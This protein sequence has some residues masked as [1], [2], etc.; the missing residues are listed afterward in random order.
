MAAVVLWAAPVA[1]DAPLPNVVIVVVDTLRADRVGAN[2]N[3]QSFTPFLDELAGRGTT[4][5]NAYATSSWTCPSV[6]SLL[7]SRYAPQHRTVAFESVLAADEVTL[8][9]VLAQRGYVAGGF[10]ANIRLAASYGYGQGFAR[11]EAYLPPPTQ[12]KVR[13]PELRRQALKWLDQRSGDASTPLVLYLQYMEPHAPYEPP[14]PYRSRL[15]RHLGE[16][17]SAAANKILLQSG[18]RG[19]GLS[20]LQVDALASLYDGEVA[21]VDTEIRVLLGELEKRGVLRNAIV[22]VTSDH[23]EEFGEHGTYGHGAT[24]YQAAIRIPLI[25]VAPDVPG[26]GVVAENVSLLDLAPTLLDLL[27]LPPAASFEGRSLVPLMRAAVPTGTWGRL[28]GLVARVFPPA[29]A[30]DVVS[31]LEHTGQKLDLRRHVSTLISGTRKVIVLPNDGAELFDLAADPGETAGQSTTKEDGPGAALV[32]RLLEQ[33]A[34]LNEGRTGAQSLPLDEATK[35]K[36]RALGYH[37]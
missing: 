5:A 21:A 10:S 6:A 23:G 35:E 22:V 28:R 19:V 11:W 36:L 14:E 27:G 9:E 3:R 24:L 37:L 12:L 13:G 15:G 7:T 29:P 18:Y 31:E 34:T 32:R 25:I 17:D 20:S 26:G 4:F 30:G 33:R 8:S 1:A 16:V 2:G